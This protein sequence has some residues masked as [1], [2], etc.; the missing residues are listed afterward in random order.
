MTLRDELL[1]LGSDCLYFPTFEEI[2]KYILANCRKGD[3]VITMGAGN[4]D[5]IGTNLLS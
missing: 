1:S 5:Q 3:L 4:I 2:E